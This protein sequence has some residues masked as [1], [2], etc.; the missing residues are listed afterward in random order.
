[1]ELIILGFMALVLALNIF[2]A[3][4]RGTR[5]SLWRLFTA[6]LA[7]VLAYFLARAFAAS[8]GEEIAM[9]LKITYGGDPSFLPLFA[10]EAG[11]DVAIGTL[12]SMVV[13]PALFLLLF[14]VLKGMLFLL[15]WLLCAVTRPDTVDGAA[16]HFIA[17]PVG[18]VI[19]LVSILAFLA[20]VM[21]YLNL[22]ATVIPEMNTGKAIDKVEALTAKNNELIAPATKTPVAAQLYSF[23]GDTVFE[24]LT[25]RK[26]D[27]ERLALKN[28]LTTLG[29]VVGNVQPLFLTP[30]EQYGEAECAAAKA[31][32][33][34]VGE[35][36]MLSV[37]LSGVLNTASNRWLLGQDFFGLVPPGA[38]PNGNMIFSAFLE[39]LATSTKE[40][41]G[42]DLDF[43]ADAFSLAVRYDV[44]AVIGTA[45]E[46]E[47]A[48]LIVNTGFLADTRTLIAAHPRMHGVGV[49]LVDV[50][51]RSAL[52]GMGL[53]E[54]VGTEC[55]AILT[56]MTVALRATPTKEDGSIDDVAL[57]QSLTEIFA[58]HEIAVGEASVSLVAQGVADHFTAEELGALTDEEALA[59]LAE[60]FEGVDLTGLA[61]PQP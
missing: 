27:G 60:R 2:L 32:A 57:A 15:Y 11:A 45:E 50:G 54:D 43:F 49:A 29:R 61:V 31:L 46:N 14:W 39:V 7:A 53:P 56:E 52:K 19:A 48:A 9:W 23:V 21:G 4:V 26:W 41:V 37:M 59:R 8:I 25:S 38:G 30:R 40:N 3:L 34:N 17:V 47:L 18:L 16:S 35:S 58:A 55:A 36:H 5:K 42:Q 24:A 12:A 6:V 33:T 13:A 28:E 1:M 10:G 22:A 20:P 44:L 51:M